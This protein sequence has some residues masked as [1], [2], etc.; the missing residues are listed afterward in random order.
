M[1]NVVPDT[2]RALREL[3]TG[4]VSADTI[5]GAD[6]WRDLA[7]LAF[8][9]V[10]GNAPESK[11]VAY[12]LSSIFFEFWRSQD[13]RPVPSSEA[14]KLARLAHLP[15]TRCLDFLEQSPTKDDATSVV[16]PLIDLVV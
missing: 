14:K 8:A 16:S 15:I 4:A 6:V 13:E 1:A 10:K 3:Y 5:G 12:C 11:V 9:C 7:R 2:V